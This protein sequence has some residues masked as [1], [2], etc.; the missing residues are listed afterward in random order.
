M[1]KVMVV[2]DHALIRRG[3][4]MLLEGYPD[5]A[6]VGEASNGDEAIQKAVSER[7][8]VIFM[9]IS[10]PDGLDGFTAAEEILKDNQ[11]TKI[12]L[13]SMHDE[14]VY[15]QK[16]VKLNVCGYILKK[17]ESSELYE[18]AQTVHNGGRYYNVGI[19]DEQISKL[20]QNREEEKSI[21]S[22]REKEIVRLT[23]LGYTNKQVSEKLFISPKTVEN[24]KANIMRKL[25][26]NNKS[27]L[28]Q[29][30]LNNNYLELNTK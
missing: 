1:I 21:L 25:E 16:A 27:E 3:I 9:D 11:G 30:G 7:P 28:I 13:L 22:I 4:V 29:Y 20:F 8:D 6:I 24:H 5:I 18:A 19:P 2:D 14:E 26:L 10:M 17:S 23:I 15:I 12:V